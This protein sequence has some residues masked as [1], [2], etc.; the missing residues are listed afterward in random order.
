MLLLRFDFIQ[1]DPLVMK[2]SSSSPLFLVRHFS[3]YSCVFSTECYDKKMNCNELKSEG[4]CTSTDPIVEHDVK[5]NCLITCGF[6]SKLCHIVYNFN[7][8]VC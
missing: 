6:C 3:L 4:K 8:K 2:I 7:L 5:S 1:S